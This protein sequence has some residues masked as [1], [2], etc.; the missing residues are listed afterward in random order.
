VITSD[1]GG[2]AEYVH[3]E[4][5]GLVFRHR[6]PTDLSVQMQRLA[7]DPDLARRLGARGYLYSE[8]GDV[9][10]MDEHVR[11]VEALYARALGA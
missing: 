3:H 5:N 2:M 11:V 4:V 1:A 9:P 7:D 10:G 8:T 6:N